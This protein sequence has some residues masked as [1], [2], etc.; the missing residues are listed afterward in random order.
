MRSVLRRSSPARLRRLRRL[1]RLLFL[2]SILFLLPSG[3]PPA[4]AGSLRDRL[5]RWRLK[6]DRW[7]IR[8]A[9]SS[10]ARF[11]AFNRDRLV[12]GMADGSVELMGF[13]RTSGARAPEDL[14]SKFVVIR[15]RGSR[16]RVEKKGFGF[17]H[18]LAIPTP[19]PGWLFPS[20]RQPIHLHDVKR[21]KTHHLGRMIRGLL[22]SIEEIHPSGAGQGQHPHW[23]ASINMPD[24]LSMPVL[25]V[26]GV[27][28]PK[29]A[30]AG[31]EVT[32][33]PAHLARLGYTVARQTPDCRIYVAPSA[34]GRWQGLDAVAVPSRQP[35]P[36]A[37]ADA[38]LGR[39]VQDLG[40]VILS[41]GETGGRVVVA[42]DDAQFVVR[43]FARPKR[44]GKR[45][46][47]GRASSKGRVSSNARGATD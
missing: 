13:D 35:A 31:G 25:H 12:T 32:D 28:N 16:A 19:R 22:R 17:E 29:V 30:A 26:H 5:A 43:A 41:R 1:R 27:F 45:R 21:S 47:K 38:M 6:L 42:R 34:K 15:N 18:L 24:L 8:R 37:V 44:K 23:V 14:R 7:K 4:E 10:S 36:G 39:M 33:W 9:L 2:L 3:S 20:A 40:A 46:P 11:T